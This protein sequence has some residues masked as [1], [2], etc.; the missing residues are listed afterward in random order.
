[1]RPNLLPLLGGPCLALALFLTAAGCGRQGTTTSSNTN[2]VAPINIGT[3]DLGLAD[4]SSNPV[5]IFVYGTVIPAVHVDIKAQIPGEISGML[6]NRGDPVKKG[7]VLARFSDKTMV[8]RVQAAR[9]VLSAAERDQSATEVL[10]KA[11]AASERANANAGVNV[12]SAKAQL[13]Q[14]EESIDNAE[15]TSPID[16]VVTERLINAGETAVPGQKLFTVINSSILEMVSTVLPTDF[17]FVRP[18]MTALLKFDSL[19]GAPLEGEV[20]RIDPIADAQTRRVSVDIRIRNSDLRVVPGIFGTGLILT[21]ASAFEKVLRIPSTAV[22]SDSGGVHVL[23]ID[24]DRIARRKVR[25]DDLDAGDGTIRVLEGIPDGSR[26]LLNPGKSV[27]E[28]QRVNL[29]KPRTQSSGK[30]TP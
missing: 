22:R 28:G 3:E 16:G 10:F 23:L 30:P 19:K 11:G 20:V 13:A 25:L 14:A 5:G 8:A 4:F 2:S 12:D 7:Q 17:P 29:M 21:N 6:V 27:V 18:G 26:Y 15:V 9:A 24:G 1:M